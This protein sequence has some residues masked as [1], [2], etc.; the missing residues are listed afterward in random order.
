MMILCFCGAGTVSP[1]ME[2]KGETMYINSGYLRNS[3]IDF[4]DHTRPLVVGSAGTYRLS[5]QMTTLPTHRPRGRVDYQILYVATGKAH[6]F[7]NGREE[8]VHAGSMVLYCPIEEQKYV[9]YAADHPEVFWVH[10]TGYDVRNILR[11]Y[12][13]TPEQHVYRTGTRAEYRWIF[14]RIILELQL[15]KP[16]YEEMLASLL[17]D[18]LLLI[19]RQMELGRQPNTIQ[20]EIEE[21]VS[22]FSENYNRDISVSD[23]ARSRHIS[24]NYFIRNLKQYIGMTP[25]QYIAS[26]RMANAQMLLENS[27]Y[28]IQEI[29]S[30]V[31]YADALYFGRLF[32]RETGMT[33]S[34]YRKQFQNLRRT[35]DQTRT[36]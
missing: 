2:R 31:G 25:K 26:I 6:F 17:N 36:K 3:R 16:L 18:L 14:Q 30:F 15:C 21:A 35:S 13:L 1:S 8:I 29:A 34:Q 7:F 20:N 5:S 24:T 23:Y 4:K 22:Y 19:C 10:F 28:T 11:Y 32:K 27:G 12:H 33:P 9:Y